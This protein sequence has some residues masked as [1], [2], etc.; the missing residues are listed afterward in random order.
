MRSGLRWAAGLIVV[1]ALACAGAWL[2]GRVRGGAAIHF[3]LDDATG[4]EPGTGVNLSGVRAGVV[5]GMSL[6]ADPS[7]GGLPRARVDVRLTPEAAVLIDPARWEV[8]VTTSPLPGFKAEVSFVRHEAGEMAALPDGA[9]RSRSRS[10]VAKQVG[11]AFDALLAKLREL[12]G[13][14]RTGRAWGRDWVERLD[15]IVRNVEEITANAREVD[16]RAA[17]DSLEQMGASG[18]EIMRK[19]DTT[20]SYVNQLLTA[21]K[22]HWLFRGAFNEPLEYEDLV[23]FLIPPDGEGGE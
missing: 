6:D 7:R 19:A 23:P 10:A 5:T 9:W 1:L 3:R 8:V 13:G 18:E 16:L 17:A 20:L 4:I 11:Q 14:G 22:R 21:L 2:S 12:R 15:G